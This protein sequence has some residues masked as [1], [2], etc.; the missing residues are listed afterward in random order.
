MN[1][2]P[3]KTIYLQ[4]ETL[5]PGERIRLIK[6]PFFSFVFSQ[7]KYSGRILTQVVNNLFERV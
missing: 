1:V 2:T 5:H 3:T 7:H 6:M 4:H